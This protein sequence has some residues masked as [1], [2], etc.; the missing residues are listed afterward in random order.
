MHD[1]RSTLADV[2][3]AL[4]APPSR[5]TPQVGGARKRKRASWGDAAPEGD[6][7]LLRGGSGGAGAGAPVLQRAPGSRRSSGDGSGG[8]SGSAGPEPLLQWGATGARQRRQRAPARAPRPAASMDD[9]E[10][11]I[12]GIMQ[13]ACGPRLLQQQPMTA[14]STAPCGAAHGGRPQQGPAVGARARKQARP[15]G[16]EEQEAED[17]RLAMQLMEEEEARRRRE[18]DYARVRGR[19]RAAG[20]WQGHQAAGERQQAGLRPL[21][22]GTQ[23][24]GSRARLILPRSFFYRSK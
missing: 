1:A 19:A 24:L 17:A 5:S 22:G 11:S 10:V 2:R 13:S 6:V 14:A 20:E 7:A 23:I 12:V 9:D 8:G 15:K 21:L 18:M 4:A 3:S 16:K